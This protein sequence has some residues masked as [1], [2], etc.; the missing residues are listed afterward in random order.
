MERGFCPLWDVPQLRR[1]AFKKCP[2][3]FLFLKQKLHPWICGERGLTR[4]LSGWGILAHPG[5]VQRTRGV[6][7]TISLAWRH[8]TYMGGR[9]AF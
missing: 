8:G 4:F 7:V 9:F 2:Q 6:D 1:G 3:G 5:K